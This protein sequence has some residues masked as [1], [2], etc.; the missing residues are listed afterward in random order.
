M[1]LSLSL[2]RCSAGS[3]YGG[4]TAGVPGRQFG[5]CAGLYRRSYGLVRFPHGPDL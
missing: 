1:M 4:H 5:Y 2:G 3:P